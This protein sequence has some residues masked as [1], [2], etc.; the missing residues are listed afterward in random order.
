M[1]TTSG[2]LD[3]CRRASGYCQIDALNLAKAPLEKADA[4]AAQHE[5]DMTQDNKTV[6]SARRTLADDTTAESLGKLL[7]ANPRGLLIAAD[8]PRAL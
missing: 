5:R 7:H 4:Q 8:E 1:V 2:H 6:P 3:C